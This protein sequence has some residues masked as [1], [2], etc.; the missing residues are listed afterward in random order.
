MKKSLV[1]LILIIFTISCKK[2]DSFLINGHIKNV[3]Q[4]YIYLSRVDINTVSL[5]DSSKIN[6]QGNFRIR[7]K[8]KEPDF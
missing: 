1:L 6:K 5:I 8:S 7:I 4:K 2:N 3:K